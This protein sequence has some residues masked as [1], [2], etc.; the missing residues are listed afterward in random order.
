MKISSFSPKRSALLRK[1]LS[2]LI[3]CVFFVCVFRKNAA[4]RRFHIDS[5]F[6]FPYTPLPH[7][8]AAPLQ[9]LP[10]RTHPNE[11]TCTKRTKKNR[12]NKNW[13]TSVGGS[14]GEPGMIR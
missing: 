11:V 8:L 12:K 7:R 4:V 6:P 14:G 2:L 1:H 5:F 9:I 10:E 13:R 3:T